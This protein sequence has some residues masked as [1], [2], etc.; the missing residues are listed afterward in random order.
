MNCAL[1]IGE[2]LSD[3]ELKLHVG[4]HVG[5]FVVR[6]G[7]ISGDGVNITSR[8][9]AI[10]E[11]HAPIISDEV[12]HAVQDQTHLQFEALIG[13]LAKIGALR[14]ISRTSVIR[15]KADRQVPGPDREGARRRW[16]H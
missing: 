15:Y 4:I 5:E 7:E 1:A 10:S 11:G 8:I 13:D 12:H 14:V 16:D 9:R 2:A 6:D 3:D